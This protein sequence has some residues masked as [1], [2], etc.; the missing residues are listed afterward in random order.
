MMLHASF[1]NDGSDGITADRTVAA[2]GTT[3]ANLYLAG[4]S[5]LGSPAMDVGRVVAVSVA[6]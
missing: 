6:G 1:Q 5:T 3:H 4:V 2:S